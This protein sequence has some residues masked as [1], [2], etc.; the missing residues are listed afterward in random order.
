M[1]LLLI[2]HSFFQPSMK[3]TV[4][5]IT[6]SPK[7]KGATWFCLPKIKEAMNSFFESNYTGLGGYGRVCRH[8]VVISL[9]DFYVLDY[10]LKYFQAMYIDFKHF[11]WKNL[12]TRA[13][14]QVY[15]CWELSPQMKLSSL[16]RAESKNNIKGCFCIELSP[17]KIIRKGVFFLNN[18]VHSAV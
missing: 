3:F 8:A 15:R 14:L 16:H 6:V 10:G 4:N 9:G 2:E 1:S 18:I 5:S 12:I 17:K 7:L 13:F 11:F